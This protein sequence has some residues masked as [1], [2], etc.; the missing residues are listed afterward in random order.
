VGVADA[1]VHE[2]DRNPFSG[3]APPL[4]APLGDARERGDAFQDQGPA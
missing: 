2:P 3:R 1:T 4:D